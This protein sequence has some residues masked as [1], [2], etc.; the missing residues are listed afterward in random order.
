MEKKQHN[1][2]GKLYRQ[3]KLHF[4]TIYRARGSAQEIAFG[5]AIGA[6]W[7]VFPTFGLSTLLTLFLYRFFRFNLP[8][9]I[10]AAFISNPLTSPFL[11]FISYHT[12]A[13]VLGI[14]PEWDPNNW[15]TQLSEL[16]IALFTGSTIVSTL[17][18]LL[19]YYGT[20]RLV[21]WK[22]SGEGK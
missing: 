14:D 4:Y 2:F 20:M 13:R 22:R 7:G 6:F 10:A 12:G 5:A 1:V 9:A 11:L 16:G 15:S 18:A 21:E 3:A 8:V 19:V 17:T